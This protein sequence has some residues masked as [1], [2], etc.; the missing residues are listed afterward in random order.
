MSIKSQGPT[1]TLI[2]PWLKISFNIVG[3]I[4]WITVL[5]DGCMGMDDHC[6]WIVP[7]RAATTAWTRTRAPSI[8]VASVRSALGNLDRH[9]KNK[10]IEFP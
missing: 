9:P 3:G 4:I 2:R 5:G 1:R 6:I 10:K 8:T 7:A